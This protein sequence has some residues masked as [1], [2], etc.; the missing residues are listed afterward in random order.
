MNLYFV[1]FK[2]NQHVTQ[3]ASFCWH[4][5]YK[6]CFLYHLAFEITIRGNIL[7]H[8]SLGGF[9]SNFKSKFSN[10]SHVIVLRLSLWNCR[11]LIADIFWIEPSEA[12]FSEIV[13]KIKSLAL[14]TRA[15]YLCPIYD[16]VLCECVSKRSL[17]YRSL[18]KSCENVSCYSIILMIPSG[19]SFAHQLNGCDISRTVTC[20]PFY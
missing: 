17:T 10:S 6:S 9:G 1:I 5:L 11:L 12:K 7:T 8:W 2:T 16:P 19:Q 14:R 3:F 15:G 20:D 4:D 18:S 13:L